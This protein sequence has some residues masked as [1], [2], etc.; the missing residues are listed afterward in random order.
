VLR[1][2]IVSQV[3]LGGQFWGV[4]IALRSEDEL[5]INPIEKI[6][7]IFGEV[8]HWGSFGSLCFLH[9][10]RKVRV[11]PGFQKFRRGATVGAAR[12]TSRHPEQTTR[13]R[14][15]AVARQEAR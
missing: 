2:L 1:L 8:G 5:L 4:A 9:K 13:R 10:W 6:A 11:S 7:F 12:S 14:D 15:A 3:G